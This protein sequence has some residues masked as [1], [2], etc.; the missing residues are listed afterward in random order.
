MGNVAYTPLT[1]ELREAI[2]GSKRS[3]AS[4]A[5][6]V[7]MSP[8]NVS[9]FVNGRSGVSFD[10]GVKLARAAGY[11]LDVTSGEEE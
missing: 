6:E 4:I 9:R 2:R 10:L 11:R 8:S 3:Q 1:T 5:A 7:G